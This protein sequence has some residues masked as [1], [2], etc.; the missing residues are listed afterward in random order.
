VRTFITISLGLV[1]LSSMSFAN[2]KET[3]ILERLKKKGVK[4]E[5][6]YHPEWIV[7]YSFNGHNHLTKVNNSHKW[8]VPHHDCFLGP[9]KNASPEKFSRSITC[10]GKNLGTIECI[11]K[12]EE[13]RCKKSFGKIDVVLKIKKYPT[14][15]TRRVIELEYELQNTIP[16]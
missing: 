16:Y 10:N 2:E 1:L 7:L 9:V 13:T 11:A 3:Q 6:V 14:M 4:I 12:I 8:K 5:Y 15:K